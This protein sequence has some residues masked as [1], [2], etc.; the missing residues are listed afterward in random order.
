MGAFLSTLKEHG[1]NQAKLNAQA[2]M[3]EMLVGLFHQET[4]NVRQPNGSVITKQ[5]SLNIEY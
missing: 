1:K 2:F 4:G 5:N 3:P